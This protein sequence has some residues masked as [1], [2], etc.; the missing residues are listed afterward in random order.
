MTAL[1]VLAAPADET[2]YML[3]RAQFDFTISFHIVLAALSIGLSNYLA[4]LV[5]LWAPGTC[6][7]L[8]SAAD[9]S[10]QRRQS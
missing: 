8:G 7:R 5:G 4:V 9:I 2:A 1:A 10:S 3:A 6:S